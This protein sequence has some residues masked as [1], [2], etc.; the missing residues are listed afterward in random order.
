MLEVLKTSEAPDAKANVGGN[1]TLTILKT[2]E[3]QCAFKVFV[4]E[5]KRQEII[6]RVVQLRQAAQWGVHR[7][8]R[9]RTREAEGR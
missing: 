1:L 8:V 4:H 2:P 9:T 7:N 5:G 3:G 6:D